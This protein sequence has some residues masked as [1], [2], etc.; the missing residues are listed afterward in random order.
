MRNYRSGDIVLP[1]NSTQIIRAV[2]HTTLKYQIGNDIV[3]S[4]GT[5]LLGADNKAGIAAIWMPRIS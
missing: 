3:T 1:G 4:D 5:T 2:D